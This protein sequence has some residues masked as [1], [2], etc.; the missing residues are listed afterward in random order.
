MCGL[1]YYFEKEGLATTLVCF[2]REHAEAIAPPR[3]LWL[4]MPMGRPFGKPNDADFQK[5]IIRAAFALLDAP[6]GPVLADYP[7]VIP[8]RDGRMTHALPNELVSQAEDRADPAALLAKIQAEVAA[9]RPDYDGA[10]KTRG[11]TTVGA[12]G[13]EIEELA[14]F[15]VSW[16][17]G[18]KVKSPRKSVPPLAMLKLA[19]ED[20]WAYYTETASGARGVT[21]MEE[22]GDWFWAETEAAKAILALE[23]LSEDSENRALRQLVELFL[24]VP[25]FWA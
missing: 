21:G 12:S 8:V 13:L 2:V 19:C 18:E 14:P 4:D 1:A 6:E 17:G 5:G 20:L 22:L 25:R 16:L 10:V 15:I 23:V 9:L 7:E 3:A 24:I 11:R